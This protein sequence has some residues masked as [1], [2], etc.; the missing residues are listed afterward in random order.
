MQSPSFSCSICRLPCAW[1]SG[2]YFCEV[3][4]P[5]SDLLY[6]GRAGA[7]CTVQASVAQFAVLPCAWKPGHYFY[8]PLESDSYLFGV[9]LLPEEYW[10]I[11]FLLG[12]AFKQMFPHPA[13]C[14]A[15]QWIHVQ[16]SV[17]RGYFWKN[18]APILREGGL[19][20]T[21]T[22]PRCS[23]DPTVGHIAGG[24]ITAADVAAWESSWQS[25]TDLAPVEQAA[26]FSE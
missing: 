16:A 11:G 2:H 18:F 21:M 19:G 23:S 14:L 5:G 9:W 12:D 3:L 20:Q 10:K 26:R 1:K 8:E 6:R 13:Q 7:V 24:R 15:R 17:C 25:L 22:I 4:V